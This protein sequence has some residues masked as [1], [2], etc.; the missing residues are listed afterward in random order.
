MTYLD[1]ENSVQD[2]QPVELFEFR[3]GSLYYR[4]TSASEEINYQGQVFSPVYIKRDTIA[5]NEDIN[6]GGLKLTL[7]RD[8]SFGVSYLGATPEIVTTVTVY[9]GH[10]GDPDGEYIA[11]WKGRILSAKAS[12]DTITLECESIFS[13]MKRAGLRARFELQCRHGLYSAECTVSRSS[14]SAT[15]NIVGESGTTLTLAVA[16]LQ[17]DGYYTGGILEN[18]EGD[19]RFIVSHTGSSIRINR[20]FSKT[21]NNTT[22]TIN[23]GCDKARSTCINKFNN[24]LNY[25]GF[26]YIPSRNPFGGSIV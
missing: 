13:S 17:P 22:V 20:P 9:R 25:G 11:Y 18:D 5:M 3:R 1:I 10:N 24:L 2:A 14:F 7:S 21:I 23:P 8:N 16:A 19:L 4:M 12:G 6:K 26:P 15:G